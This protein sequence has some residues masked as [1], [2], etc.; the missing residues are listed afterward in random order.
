MYDIASNTWSTVGDLPNGYNTSDC[1]GFGWEDRAY[2]IGG[3]DENYSAL[4][5]VFSIDGTAATDPLSTFTLHTP[6]NV[7]RGDI[8][9]AMDV[10]NGFV[11]VAGGFTH[12]NDFCEPH[13]HAELYNVR[14]D[15]WTTVASMEYARADKALVHLAGD[16]GIFYAIGG[17]RQV[18][19]FCELDVKPEPGERTIPLFEVECFNQTANTWT[20]VSNLPVHRFRFP[21]VSEGDKAYGFGG[22]FGFEQSC[23]CFKT[24]PEILVYTN[25]SSGSMPLARL[26][27]T[28]LL[29]VLS[30]GLM[31]LAV[32]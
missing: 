32:F 18:S 1:T 10:A 14:T 4:P 20:R 7:E 22:Q 21:A 31:L 5:T 26:T 16:N 2:F 17:E 12:K 30:G 23:D 13:A 3:Y 28:S 15:T 24:T 29:A 27:L 8:S 6:M 25:L 11:L 19:G 9:S